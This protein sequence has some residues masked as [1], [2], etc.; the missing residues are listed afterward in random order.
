MNE[1]I[2]NLKIVYTK[3]RDWRIVITPLY[4][5]T[6]TQS[7]ADEKN[8]EKNALDLKRVHFRSLDKRTE[9]IK[10][11]EFEVE[12]IFGYFSEKKLLVKSKLSNMKNF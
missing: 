9:P 5:K 7:M 3:L 10:K 12:A 8:F 4:Q 6:L 1:Y 11:T 2:S